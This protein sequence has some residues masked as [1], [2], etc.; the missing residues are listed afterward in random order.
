MSLE[1]ENAFPTPPARRCYSLTLPV[2]YSGDPVCTFIN[3]NEFGCSGI[4]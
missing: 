4:R 2:A 3:V 1:F